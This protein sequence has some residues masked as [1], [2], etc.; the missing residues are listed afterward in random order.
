[1]KNHNFLCPYQVC[2]AWQGFAFDTCWRMDMLHRGVG[3]L[4]PLLWAVWIWLIVED[5]S[6]NRHY[7]KFKVSCDPFTIHSHFK[8][9]LKHTYEY[10]MS[11]LNFWRPLGHCSH[12]SVCMDFAHSFHKQAWRKQK[13]FQ[14][15]RGK[16]VLFSCDLGYKKGTF[17][18]PGKTV[19]A[20]WV[21]RFL[22]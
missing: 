14:Y 7:L 21:L 1:M 20:Q 5:T 13:V 22:C 16:E 8:D 11:L 6:Y 4:E 9:L 19:V 2:I 3:M 18:L 10:Y 15:L 17:I 12:P